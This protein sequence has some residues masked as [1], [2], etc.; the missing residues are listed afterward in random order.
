MALNAAAHSIPFD[1][2][3]DPF[4]VTGETVF[5]LRIGSLSDPADTH[6]QTIGINQVVWDPATLTLFVESDE[7]LDQHTSY[8]LIVTNGVRDAAGDPIEASASFTDFRHDLNFG[9]TRDLQLKRYREELI[10]SL[11]GDVLSSAT[12]ALSRSEIAVASVF[13][14][15]SVTAT[16]E[17]IRDQIKTGPAP[18]VNFNIG[19]HGERTVFPLNTVLGILFGQQVSTVGPLNTVPVPTP[20]L[21]IFPGLWPQSL[22]GNLM[23]KTLR[24]Q[25]AL[26][27]QFLRVRECRRSKGRRT[28]SSIF[29]F[30]P[31]LD[32]RM[33]GRLPSSVRAL[34]TTKTTARWL[35]LPRLRIM[36]LLPLRSIQWDTAL[37]PEVF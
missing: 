22:L 23:P 8:L 28:F 35:C 1:G 2:A 32:L 21:Q 25:A 27:R 20:A 14:T 15:G 17:K 26:F 33:D 10:R 4:T 34:A 12:L 24:L 19:L 13:T 5:L 11:A 6:P 31:G 18:V 30:L 37:A 29:S 9:Q 36:E 7:H 16:L 3:I